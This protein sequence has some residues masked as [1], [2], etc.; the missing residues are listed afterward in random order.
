MISN[1]S[2]LIIYGTINRIDLLLN[3]FGEITIAE[4]VFNE[5][6]V[7]G[8]A[9]NSPDAFIIEKYVTSNKIKVVAL[10]SDVK[11]NAERLCAIYS[12]LDLGEAQ[13]VALALQKK[14]REVLIDES[15]ARTIARFHGLNPRGSLGVLLLAF[16]NKLV[17]EREVEE[18][19]SLILSTKF[20]ISASVLERFHLML[21]RLK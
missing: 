18:M 9:I 21:R 5:V 20:R 10:S 7:R 2:P 12:Q 4:E 13:T 15:I 8:K 3:V 6:V 11:R 14:S 17:T 1:A 19:L 16:K